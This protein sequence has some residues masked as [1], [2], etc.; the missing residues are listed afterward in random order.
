[1]LGLQCAPSSTFH[2]LVHSKSPH[3][4]STPSTVC[5]NQPYPHT[6][7][8]YGAKKQFAKTPSTATLLDKHGK[9]FIQQ[10]CGKF[11]FYGRAVDSTLLIPLSAI[12]SQSSAP[13]TDTLKQACQLLDYLA[14]QEDAILTYK[15]S[16]IKLTIH[17]DASYLSEPKAR[18]H[19]GGHFFLSFDKTIPRNNV[20]IINI[21]HV[22]K[23]VM[24]SATEAELA[25][26]HIMV[27]EAVY[28]QIILEEMGHKQPPTPIQTNNAMADAVIN[29]KIQPKHTKAM[30]MHFHLLCDR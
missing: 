20:T 2:A 19:A 6:Q 29:G 16:N 5:Q 7:V 24:S 13:T 26:L 10:V 1:M 17:S 15:C 23:N 11:L 3:H 12:A 27:H 30:D 9:K 18:S 14:T 22:I 4:I 21:A 8:K 28:I 25:T